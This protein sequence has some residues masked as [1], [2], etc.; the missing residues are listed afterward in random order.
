MYNNQDDYGWY[1]VGNTRYYNKIQAIQEHQSNRLPIRWNFCDQI[2]DQYR[3]DLEPTQTLSELYA[4]RAWDI[5]NRYDYLVLHFSGGTDSGNIL[6]TFI[7][8]G[9]HLDEVLIRGAISQTKKISGLVP[10]SEQYAECLTQAVP[11]AEWARD[12]HYPDLKISLVDTTENIIDFFKQNPDWAENDLPTLHPGHAWKLDMNSLC[13]H[14]D[15]LMEKGLRICHIVGA[16]KPKVFWEKNLFYTRWL[17]ELVRVHYVHWQRHRDVPYY[18]ELFYWSPSAVLMQIKQLHLVKK[19]I[20]ASG[21]TPEQY[22]Q[23]TGRDSDNFIARIVYDRKLP[24]ITEHLKD[25]GTSVIRDRDHWFGVKQNNDGFQSW[26]KG[27][28][29]LAKTLPREWYGKDNFYQGGI[30]GM[31]S[32]PR[33]LGT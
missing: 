22:N 31:W 24:I 33:Y 10:A 11:L 15:K 32:K 20:K 8:N 29:Y 14:Y 16:E 13:P 19:Y 28:D 7:N 2:Y 6:E 5:R 30:R 9:I 12:N 21:L 18:F 25:Q 26:K 17:D 3:W 4:A 27:L 1:E 23:I